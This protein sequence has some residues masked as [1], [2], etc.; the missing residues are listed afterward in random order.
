M[1]RA[2]DDTPPSAEPAVGFAALEAKIEEV[3]L[4]AAIETE[5]ALEDA[6]EAASVMR[7]EP[8]PSVDTGSVSDR[9]SRPE[10]RPLG[11]TS[12]SSGPTTSLS[13]L[14]GALAGCTESTLQLHAETIAALARARS[15]GDLI[16]AQMAFGTQAMDLYTGNM[17]RLIEATPFAF[18]GV[19]APEPRP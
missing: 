1:P 7:S 19:L 5:L 11:S 8:A 15:P 2:K 12:R 13:G 10:R 3:Q 6:A 4:D 16:A 14:F 17:A 9:L 18:G